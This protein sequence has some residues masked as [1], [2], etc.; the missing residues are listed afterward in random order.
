[1]CRLLSV[2]FKDVLP[3]PR[4][5]DSLDALTGA[6][7][8]SMMDLAS[9]YNQVPVTERDKAKTTFCTPFALF[10]WNC[11]PFRFPLHSNGSWSISDNHQCQ[12]LLLYLD[13]IVVFLSTVSQ[14]LGVVGACSGPAALSTE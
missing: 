3:L 1:M 8:F 7:W 12:S 4:I 5:E 10:E 14:N 2:E 13:D 9:G 11:M 6:C